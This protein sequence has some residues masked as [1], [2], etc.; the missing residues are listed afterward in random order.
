MLAACERVDREIRTRP[1]FAHTS[2][3]RVDVGGEVVFDR[4]Y[5][6][7]RSRTCSR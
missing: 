6:G 2:H 5:R 7:R 1:E 3:L 4:H